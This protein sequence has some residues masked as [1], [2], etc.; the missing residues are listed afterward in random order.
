M[1]AG[2]GAPA[3]EDAAAIAAGVDA[4]SR[5][6]WC[7]RRVDVQSGIS[8]SC[9]DRVDVVVRD[10]TVL[11]VPMSELREARECAVAEGREVVVGG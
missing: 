5:W 9:G 3:R 10:R 2:G 6:R 1:A 8:H 4:V 11:V 7:A